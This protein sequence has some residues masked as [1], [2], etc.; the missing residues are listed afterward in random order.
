M[1][2]LGFIFLFPPSQKTQFEEMNKRMPKLEKISYFQGNLLERWKEI[3][4]QWNK[5]VALQVKQTL[6]K[7]GQ[8]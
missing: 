8:V 5:T 7:I 3:C 1:G 2:I 6:K 4:G